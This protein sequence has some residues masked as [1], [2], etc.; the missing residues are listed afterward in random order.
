[1]L[2]YNLANPRTK[3][4]HGKCEELNI[5]ILSQ[6]TANLSKLFE[7]YAVEKETKLIFVF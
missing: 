2:I 4:I 5:V 7:T 6:Q 3:I 1:M